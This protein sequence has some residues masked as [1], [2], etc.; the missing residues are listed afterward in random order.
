MARKKKAELIPRLVVRKGATL[1][2]IYAKVRKEFSAADLQKYTV[3][4][5]LV[6]GEQLLAELEQTHEQE[7]QKKRR[8]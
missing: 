2:E 5:P 7:S 6:P 4:E 8:A 3:D 1:R